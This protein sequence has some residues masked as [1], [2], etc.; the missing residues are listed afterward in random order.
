MVTERMF[1]T[2]AKGLCIDCVKRQASSN[3][4]DKADSERSLCISPVYI[5]SRRLL[6]NQPPWPGRRTGSDVVETG[7]LALGR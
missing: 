5:K 6:T 2:Y 4:F 7:D 3:A 1:A